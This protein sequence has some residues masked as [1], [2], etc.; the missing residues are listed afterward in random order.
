[1]SKRNISLL[2]IEDNPGDVR[3]ISELL[4]DEY[5]YRYEITSAESISEA[6]E[7]G[8]N[9]HFDLILLDLSLPDSSGLSTVETA[10]KLFPA[11]PIVVLTGYSDES[12][13]NEA[14]K[15]GVEDYFEKNNLASKN[16]FLSTMRFSIER[17]N[18]RSRF[19]KS[20]LRFRKLI[21]ENLD[22]VVVT[23]LEGFI[24]Y[25]NPVAQKMFL[26]NEEEMIG[27]RFELPIIEDH[28]SEHVIQSPDGEPITI[29]LR[30]RQTEW[31][32]E[33]ARLFIMRDISLPIKA[34][35]KINEAYE[36]LKR[37]NAV[38]IRWSNV[39][40]FP[41]EYV[42]DNIKLLCGYT[43]EQFNTGLVDWISITHPDD[44]ERL[45]DLLNFPEKFTE[46]GFVM[47][48]RILTVNGE[49]KWVQ[50]DTK[51]IRDLSGKVMH[52]ESV[53]IDIHE[54]KKA[55]QELNIK[56]EEL[57]KAIGTTNR[58]FSIIAHD[59]IG[60]YN[61][62]IGL[63][64]VLAEN[65]N[66]LDDEEKQKIYVTLNQAFNRHYE[67]LKNLLEWGR[68]QGDSFVFN[69]VE[70]CLSTAFSNVHSFLHAALQHKDIRLSFQYEEESSLFADQN[71]IETILRN[72]ISNAVKFSPVH[73][74]IDVFVEHDNTTTTFAVK[75][76][77]VGMTQS[78]QEKLF[79]PGVSETTIG[80]NN[81]KGNG[82]GMQ[83]CV[84]FVHKH[85]GKIWTRSSPGRGTTV[86][87]TIPKKQNN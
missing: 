77:G 41:L 39:N 53:M 32:D 14:I 81:E 26:K 30:A 20:E 78:Q 10:L 35:K 2:L 54:R 28:V 13:W 67:L 52:F 1:M 22:G 63:T 44:V 61:P 33:A 75:D 29:D 60:G 85:N 27:T 59:L 17:F 55:E 82:L 12:L 25:A 37:S 84:E 72:L 79:K 48:Y 51:A 23:N 69:P 9:N 42:S 47:E 40:G 83:L 50:N 64:D 86:F 43:A 70:F 19:E 15:L 65:A 74:L 6:T 3:L 49:E 38:L 57:N 21:E 73:S 66:L 45:E 34:R 46:E 7:K 62:L 8:R 87:F 11:S 5:Y 36:I 58:L 24:Q 80:T 4:K 16:C 68:M 71:M 56:N 31:E 76:Y 18:Y